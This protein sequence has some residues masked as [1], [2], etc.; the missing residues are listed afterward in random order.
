MVPDREPLDR[1]NADSRV[2]GRTAPKLYRDGDLVMS[3]EVEG[4]LIT[5]PAPYVGISMGRGFRE[6]T[7]TLEI[8]QAEAAHVLRRAAFI[9]LGR[10]IDLQA[11]PREGVKASAGVCHSFQPEVV[12]HS[13]RMLATSRDYSDNP[14]G[15]LLN[16]N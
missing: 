1:S 5:G 14:Q 8:D 9:A 13:S 16:I 3:W 10:L 15:L 11:L 12:K 2:G 4:D 7:E 6:W